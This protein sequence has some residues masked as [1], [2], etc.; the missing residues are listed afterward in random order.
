MNRNL[1][2]I[3]IASHIKA[4]FLLGAS[5]NIV[6][7]ATLDHI[8]SGL[9]WVAE[10]E[11]KAI[12]GLNDPNDGTTAVLDF[13]GDSSDPGA[14]Y[15]D[16]GSYFYFR[17]RLAVDTVSASTFSGA[18]LVMIDRADYVY[19][20][21]ISGTNDNGSLPDF[22]FAW[23]SKSNDPSKHGLEM[24]HIST[25]DNIWNGLNF[26]DLDG[27]AGQK[28]TV[29]INGDSRTTDGYIRS[30]DNIITTNL[31][32]TTYLDYAVSWSYLATYTELNRDQFL[33]GEWSFALGSIA[34]A[35]DHN[36]L[37]ADVGGGATLAS[38]TTVGISPIPEPK[39]YAILLAAAIGAFA[40]ITRRRRA[41]SA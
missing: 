29:D 39:S 40:L 20:N 2:A 9:S 23:D 28:L 4:L 24:S 16:D 15:A 6:S 8:G 17:M 13:V 25:T 33:N 30:I 3:R 11:W 41:H 7:A 31:G 5:L 36:N 18:H 22:A 35:T 32:T 12:E 14:Y 37:N 21:E 26:D 10:N 1:I 34:N 38:P 27:S 19:T